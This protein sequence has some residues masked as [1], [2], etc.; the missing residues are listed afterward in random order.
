MSESPDTD[1]AVRPRALRA[2]PIEAWDA[3][4]ANY[5]SSGTRPAVDRFLFGLASLNGPPG[6]PGGAGNGLSLS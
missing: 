4:I 5:L 3:F 6:A 2:V 1:R